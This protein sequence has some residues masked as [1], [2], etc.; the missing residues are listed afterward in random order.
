MSAAACG[1]FAIHISDLWLCYTGPGELQ[2]SHFPG[3]QHAALATMGPA[4]ANL[5]SVSRAELTSQTV[6]I[7]GHCLGLQPC[8]FTASSVMAV[9]WPLTSLLILTRTIV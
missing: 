4:Q 5:G 8:K 7:Q 3:M 2:C 1:E 9:C 6:Q